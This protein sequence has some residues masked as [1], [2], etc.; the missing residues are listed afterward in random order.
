MPNVKGKPTEAEEQEVLFRWASFYPE[1]RW[2][3]AVPNGGSRH[4]KEAVNLKRQGV[5]KG[6]SDICLPL[7]KG[8]YHGLYIEMKAGRNTPSE[9]QDDFL[10][11]VTMQGYAGCVCWGC[12]Q[13]IKAI[14]EY[15]NGGEVKREYRTGK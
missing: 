8:K 9:D 1:L 10:D 15:L 12:E 7:P 14:E 4:P 13:A 3:Y 6:V 5:K 11:F 2:M